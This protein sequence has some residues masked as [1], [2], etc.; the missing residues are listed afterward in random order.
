M[1][2]LLLPLFPLEIVLLPEEILPL[3]IFEERYKEMI[4][5]CLA[6]RPEG[7]ERNEFGIVWAKEREI[8]SVGCTAHVS[9]ITRKYPDGRMDILTSGK[10][11][12]EVLFTDSE[13]AYLRAGVEFFEDESG[14][15]APQENEA[16]RALQLFW[17]V[18]ERLR[19]SPDIPGVPSAPYRRLSYH[20]AAFL[21]LDL[22][23]K[24]QLLVL[25]R[26]EERLRELT[27]A[28][29]EMLPQ[30]DWIEASR[31]KAGGNGNLRPHS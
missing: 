5:E 11:G 4:G 15:D 21:P 14:A 19:N 2:E 3:H 8:S 20:L 10:R 31:H 28:L 26:E 1:K 16:Q 29:E 23:L 22:G 12:F 6:S 25:R 27:H 24:Q 9:Q 17:E 13:K 30:L 18:I 7:G